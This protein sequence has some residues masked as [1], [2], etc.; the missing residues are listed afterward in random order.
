MVAADCGSSKVSEE[1][2]RRGDG[3][4]PRLRITQPAI[5]MK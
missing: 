5:A 2:K 4:D 3:Y 1:T